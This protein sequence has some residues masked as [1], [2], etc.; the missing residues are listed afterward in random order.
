MCP[1]IA[2]KFAIRCS[3]KAIFSLNALKGASLEAK[4]YCIDTR[5][6]GREEGNHTETDPRRGK[7]RDVSPSVGDPAS[8]SFCA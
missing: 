8:D 4:S 1:Q 5:S 7:A 3:L 6:K 2:V